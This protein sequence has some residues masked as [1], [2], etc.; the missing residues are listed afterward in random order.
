MADTILE[1]PRLSQRATS[2]RV[3]RLY[4]DNSNS[5]KNP[6]SPTIPPPS[7]ND[8]A[9]IQETSSCKGK[10]NEKGI[11]KRMPC[12]DTMDL[13]DAAILKRSQ[14]RSDE[15][16]GMKRANTTDSR[17]SSISTPQGKEE[18]SSSDERIETDDT[19]PNVFHGG[20]STK[21]SN[22]GFEYLDHTADI[23]L[24]AWG[25]SLSQALTELA[26]AMMGY[27]I[28]LDNVEIDHQEVS[29]RVVVAQ[30]HDLKSMVY[31]FL[32]EWLYLFHEC[33][34][35]STEVEILSI[36]DFTIHSSGRGELFDCRKHTQEGTEI[37]AITYSNMIII[38]IKDLS[39]SPMR[40]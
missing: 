21:V 12:L 19:K 6:P 23:Q 10:E 31:T 2:R 38:I 26:R 4:C 25:E 13:I 24:H 37:K 17:Y 8:E 40:L 1:E 7:Q 18:L 16:D 20:S 30:G 11:Q 15:S 36:Q 22:K 35:I 29:K 9:F 27:M 34:F 14:M 28:N 32:N 5:N 39:T 33:G 3:K